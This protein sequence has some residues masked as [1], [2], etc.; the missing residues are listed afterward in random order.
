MGTG[1]YQGKIIGTT[2]W[3]S[4]WGARTT[5]SNT[6]ISAVEALTPLTGLAGGT[7]GT[8]L[9]TTNGGVDWDPFPTSGLPFSFQ[10][11]DLEFIGAS[12]GW[13]L[14]SYSVYATT[15]GGASW[16]YQDGAGGYDLS[17]YDSLHGWACYEDGTLFA[18][19]DGGETWATQTA[20]TTEAF[21][22]VT[23][24]GKTRAWAVTLAGTIFRTVD[25]GAHWT[26]QN[27]RT[28][29]DLLR[30]RD[31]ERGPVGRRRERHDPDPR[32]Q[33]GATPR[34]GGAD[35][36]ARRQVP[37][38]LRMGLRQFPR[39]RLREDRRQEVTRVRLLAR[40]E[41]QGAD[42]EDGRR[43]QTGLRHDGERQR[44]Q[45]AADT[46]AQVRTPRRF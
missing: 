24:A 30:H 17:F 27:S 28:T 5:L 43:H 34:A 44:Q 15:D 41:H 36:R 40:H 32:L 37:D 19:T 20:D 18:T 12:R 22:G 31:G 26:R 2:N 3:G 21:Y 25:G 9:R 42:S 1:D 6:E 33:A 4:V 13:A 8:L 39:R 14:V 46:R 16:A 35:A 38:A 29:Q 23:A 45:H 11:Q 10:M 7:K